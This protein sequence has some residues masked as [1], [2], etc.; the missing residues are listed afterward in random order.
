MAIRSQACSNSLHNMRAIR[1]V[2]ALALLVIAQTALASGA[3]SS[4]ILSDVGTSTLDRA[5]SALSGVQIA[6]GQQ[7]S[8]ATVKGST[9][10][11]SSGHSGKDGI[12]TGSY[13]VGSLTASAPINK[14]T[15]TTSL[16]TLDGLANATTLELSFSNLR[17]S[18][19]INPADDPQH[20]AFAAAICSRMQAAYTEKHPKETPQSCNT[21]NVETYDPADAADFRGLFFAKNTWRL[22]WGADAKVGYQDFKFFDTNTLQSKDSSKIP[23]SSRIFLA[24]SPPYA[25]HTLITFTAQYQNAYQDSKTQTLCPTA[26]GQGSF[27]HCA[28]GPIGTPEASSHDIVSLEVRQAVVR[29]FGFSVTNSYDVK[30]HVF[31]LDLPLYFF[32]G[33]SGGLTGGLD[34]GWRNDTHKLSVGLFVGQTF[35]VWPESGS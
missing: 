25:Q 16:A 4:A 15:D 7:G 22:I 13:W 9:T 2:F 34:I 21:T 11:S 24:V 31:G 26:T 29:S 6:A 30:K 19:L 32:P 20:L 12:F 35:G 14:S 33:G 27:L 1:S 8:S 18:G 28:S 23:W 10:I 5:V 17:A 3:P